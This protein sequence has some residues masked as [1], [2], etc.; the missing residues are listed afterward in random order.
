MKRSIGILLA[1]MTG[2]QLMAQNAN[3]GF[4]LSGSVIY[5]QI[6]KLNIQLEGDAAQFAEVL[7]KERKS[8]K[9]LYFTEDAALFENHHTEDVEESLEM[10]DGANV[11]VKMAEPDNKMYTDLRAGEQIE[12]KEFMSRVFLI[13]TELP[14]G[15]WKLTGEQ[16]MILDYACQQA[17]SKEEDKE[18]IAWF[19]P[20]IAVPAGPGKYGNL[21]GLVLEVNR[22][23]GDFLLVAKSIEFKELEKGLLKKPTKGKEVSEEEYQAIVE[24][25]MKEMGV[26]HEGS[27]GSGHAVVVKIRHQ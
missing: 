16:K 7:P 11:M 21:P 13:E 18:V 4:L 9:I 25:K 23:G 15:D 2:T 27:P 10:Q 22:D 1:V 17:V 20:A 5:E 6:A 8:E 12:Q 26:E 19:T 3:N 24:E 14:K